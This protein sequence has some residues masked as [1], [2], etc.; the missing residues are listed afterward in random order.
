MA[1]NETVEDLSQQPF[2]LS[3]SHQ[4]AWRK[5]PRKFDYPMVQEWRT[6]LQG[7]RHRRPIDL[8]Q[9]IVRKVGDCIEKT[10]AVQ[11]AKTWWRPSQPRGIFPIR[12]VKLHIRNEADKPGVNPVRIQR[13]HAR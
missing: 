4:K 1:R 8:L 7:Y 12:H 6:R 9:Y 10:S 13:Q 2:R 11:N 5:A 3:V